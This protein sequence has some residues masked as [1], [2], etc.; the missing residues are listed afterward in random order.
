M[1][2][3]EGNTTMQLNNVMACLELTN[4]KRKSKCTIVIYDF[5]HHTCIVNVR[6]IKLATELLQ[7]ILRMITVPM[8]MKQSLSKLENSKAHKAHTIDFL[9]YSQWG[10]CLRTLWEFLGLRMHSESK[11]RYMP[12]FFYKARVKGHTKTLEKHGPPKNSCTVERLCT[13]TSTKSRHHVP[14]RDFVP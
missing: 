14:W 9:R 13:L 11:C 8:T 2:N 10:P 1:L 12:L 4:T 5:C 6:E 3:I 7:M